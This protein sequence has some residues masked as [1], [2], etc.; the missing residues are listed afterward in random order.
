MAAALLLSAVNY[1]VLGL[2]AS[3]TRVVRDLRGAPPLSARPARPEAPGASRPAPEPRAAGSGAREARV[4]FTLRDDEL[5][6]VLRRRDRWLGG[7]LAVAR[8]ASCRLDN[9]HVAI[10]TRN[11]VRLFGLP[12][13]RYPGFSDWALTTLPGG[14]G[15]RLHA[16]R[17]AGLPVPGVSW[18]LVRFGPSEGGW[19]VV[20]TGTRTQ[21]D[22]V[23]VGGG[24]LTVAGTIRGRG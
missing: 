15:L 14:V 17:L 10:D 12:V 1:E 3:L 22:R 19:V 7:V 8:D 2:G 20:R 23:E 24:R 4:S 5:S 11:E 18:L 9:G 13:A 21:V 6:R 16:V